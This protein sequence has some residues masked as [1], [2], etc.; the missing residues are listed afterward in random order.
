MYSKS[1]NNHIMKH[2][3]IW[4]IKLFNQDKS[5]C[6]PDGGQIGAGRMQQLVQWKDPKRETGM[7]VHLQQQAVLERPQHTAFLI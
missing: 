4:L 3:Q 5:V 2:Q 6:E 1:F 7:I